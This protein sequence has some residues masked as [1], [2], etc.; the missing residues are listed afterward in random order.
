[1]SDK[2]NDAIKRVRDYAFLLLKFR[3]RSEKEI[4]QRLKKKKFSEEI[5]RQ[6]VAFLK[7]NKFIDDENFAQFFIVAR[8]KKTLGL[9]RIRQELK[10]K[11]IDPKVIEQ[12]L[13]L[14]KKNYHPEKAIK[15]IIRKRLL[16]LKGVCPRTAKQ[17]IFAYLLRRGFSSDLVTE[18]LE[19]YN[20]GRSAK[21]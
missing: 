5:I 19:D 13:A 15:E 11:G 7:R 3:A 10:I 8:L 2:Y 16:R 20:E 12:Q 9:E 14:V 6:A 21:E 4:I 17:R 1:M 18:V